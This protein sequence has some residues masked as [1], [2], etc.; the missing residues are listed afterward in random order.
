MATLLLPC[1]GSPSALLAVRH[2]IDEFRRGEAS[3]VHLLNVQPPF[4]GY[5][6]RHVCR[7]LRADFQRERAEEELAEARRLLEAA[8]VPCFTHCEVGDTAQCIAEAARRLRCDRVL[9]GTTRKGALVRAI[10]HS[11]TNR[12]LDCC[13]VPVEVVAGAPAGMVERLGI[14]A[15]VGAGVALVL[16]SAS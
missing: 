13:A 6:A 2:A 5:V 12:L 8:G 1:D 10:E 15:G 11:L 9:I 4:S 7:Q 3:R 14:P 16:A